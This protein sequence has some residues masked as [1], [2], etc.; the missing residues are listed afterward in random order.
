MTNRLTKR[1]FLGQAA[2]AGAVPVNQ[3][4]GC[5]G[6]FL[7]SGRM[8]GIQLP[9]PVPFRGVA[10]QG[11][12]ARICRRHFSGSHNKKPR[13]GEAGFDLHFSV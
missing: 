11:R 9:S 7:V 3:R 1:A 2:A 8:E 6:A 12:Y 4:D 13:L 5:G 10:G